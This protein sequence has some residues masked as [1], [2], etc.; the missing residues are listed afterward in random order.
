GLDLRGTLP[1]DVD[2]TVRR[3]LDRHEHIRGLQTLRA[4]LSGELIQLVQSGGRLASRRSAGQR[5]SKIVLNRLERGAIL[6][7]RPHVR[8]PLGRFRERPGNA[9]LVAARDDD[10]ALVAEGLADDLDEAL[11]RLERRPLE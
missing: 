11:S 5:P 8:Q 1:Y 3:F 10:G 9:A 7:A 2:E 4:E 6:P